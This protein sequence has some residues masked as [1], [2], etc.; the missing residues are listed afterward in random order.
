MTTVPPD[1]QVFTRMFMKVFYICCVGPMLYRIR[2]LVCA[3]QQQCYRRDIS[4]L[5]FILYFLIL[6]TETYLLIESCREKHQCFNDDCFDFI[7]Q[8]I[9]TFANMEA[10]STLRIWAMLTERFV[11]LFTIATY[12]LL[13]IA[14]QT[15][16]TTIWTIW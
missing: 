10:P 2:L 3:K 14:I 5:T 6:Q 16:W 13:S 12:V 15:Y 4:K 9:H 8:R 1:W 11:C 7:C